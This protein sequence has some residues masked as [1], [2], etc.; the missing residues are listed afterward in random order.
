MKVI[1]WPNWLPAVSPSIC[2]PPLLAVACDNL[3]MKTRFWCQGLCWP[4]FLLRI[5]PH[6]GGS[7]GWHRKKQAD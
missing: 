7:A 3:S 5:R 1:A 2:Q 6:D 4:S